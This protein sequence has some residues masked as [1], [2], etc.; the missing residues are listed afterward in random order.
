MMSNFNFLKPIWSRQDLKIR[1]L[2]VVT[3]AG[4]ELFSIAVKI[5][6]IPVRFY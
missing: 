4:Y 1:T 5:Y 6:N 3:E 2:N